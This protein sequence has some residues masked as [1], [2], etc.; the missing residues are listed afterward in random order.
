M[1]KVWY[2]VETQ[3]LR[4]GWRPTRHTFDNYEDAIRE[5]GDTSR[6]INARIVKVT[7]TREVVE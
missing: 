3:D 2:V 1:E 4:W 6:N 5:M 7:E